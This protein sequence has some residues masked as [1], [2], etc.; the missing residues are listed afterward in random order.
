[1]SWRGRAL[2]ISLAALALLALFWVIVA[3]SQQES[4]PAEPVVAATSWRAYPSN[5]SARGR[6][7]DQRQVFHGRLIPEVLIR[8]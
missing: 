4:V 2:S 6:G 1:M 8:T 5:L 3:R 7:N